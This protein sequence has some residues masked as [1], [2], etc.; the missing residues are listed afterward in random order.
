MPQQHGEKQFCTDFLAYIADKS[1]HYA[2]TDDIE[3]IDYL[4]AI[5]VAEGLSIANVMK[6]VGRF[7][8]KNGKNKQDIFKAMHYLAYLYYFNFIKPNKDIAEVT[9][10]PLDNSNDGVN[11]KYTS[12]RYTAHTDHEIPPTENWFNNQISSE[13]NNKLIDNNHLTK[14]EQWSLKQQEFCE[15]H[16]YKS[17]NTGFTSENLP[18]IFTREEMSKLGY[19]KLEDNNYTINPETG[20]A[21]PIKDSNNIRHTVDDICDDYYSEALTNTPQ[22]YVD[23]ID[24]NWLIDESLAYI[25]KLKDEVS[26]VQSYADKMSQWKSQATINVDTNAKVPY[27]DKLDVTSYNKEE[28]LSDFKFETYT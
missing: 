28:P 26:T 19:K 22:P 23:N 7:G 27:V 16:N 18:N 21:F 5:D 4:D 8:K 20:D 2:G 9:D 3:L 1:N 25:K 24:N 12:M 6:Y 11:E 17:G 13:K 14:E 15:E 10:A